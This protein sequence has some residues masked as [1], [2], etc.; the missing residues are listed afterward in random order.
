MRY[1]A[2]YFDID[3]TLLD[4]DMSSQKSI[5]RS[6][7]DFGIQEDP[8]TVYA[9]YSEINLALW[10]AREL[11]Q[12]DLEKLRY[13]RFHRLIQFFRWEGLD[14][15]KFDECYLRHLSQ[16]AIVFPDVVDML[17]MLS[18][19]CFLGLIT[20]GIAFVQRSRMERSG[21]L[22]HFQDFI[23]SEEVGV[24]KPDSAI[25]EL[26]LTRCGVARGRFLYVGD[27]TSSDM[28]GAS[29]AGIDFCWFANSREPEEVILSYKYKIHR[30]SEIIRHL[31]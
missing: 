14:P 20:N 2:V 30:F 31:N 4:Y 1:S 16:S 29:R 17:S 24:S 7:T 26:A 3:G 25:F 9:K 6:L 21:I 18:G 23:I 22:H 19:R 28:A 8:Y 27:S 10:K 11:N 15:L 5:H 13:E 12:I